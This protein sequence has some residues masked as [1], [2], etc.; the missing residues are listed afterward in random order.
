[1]VGDHDDGFGEVGIFELFI[2][3]QNHARRQPHGGGDLQGDQ[4]KS[5][6]PG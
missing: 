3:H 5:E 1:M 2:G 6:K 4:G